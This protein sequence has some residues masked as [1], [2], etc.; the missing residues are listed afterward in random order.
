[1]ET[2][3]S[4]AKRD[5]KLKDYSNVE[6]IL[7]QR[8]ATVMNLGEIKYGKG[9]WQKGGEDFI[10]DIPSH[11]LEHCFGI[12]HGD[13]SVDHVAHLACNCMMLMCLTAQK[14]KDEKKK[15]I[16]SAA[17]LIPNRPDPQCP[18][19]GSLLVRKTVYRETDNPPEKYVC[20]DCWKDF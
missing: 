19:C 1:M 20:Q 10:K 11:M 9:N 13:N 4:G 17:P 8:V 5:S 3:N 2:F 12:I 7:L 6:L 18:H 15:E 16:P 14:K